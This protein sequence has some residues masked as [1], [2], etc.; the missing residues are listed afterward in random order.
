MTI[1][2]EVVIVDSFVNEFQEKNKHR[3]TDAE[4]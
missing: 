2:V 3:Q 1:L 4:A